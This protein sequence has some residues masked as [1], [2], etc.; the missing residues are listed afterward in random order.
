MLPCGT[1]ETISEITLNDLRDFYG[2]NYFPANISVVAVGGLSL[3]EFTKYINE[4]VF[5]EAR[6]G[7]RVKLIDG[8]TR[9]SAPKINHWTKRI[10]KEN[11]HLT[12]Q[13]LFRMEAVVARNI[14][15]SLLDL[16]LGLFYDAL[17]REFR[18]RKGWT[19]SIYLKS[20]YFPEA[21]EVSMSFTFPFNKH[22]LVRQAV[23]FCINDLIDNS[24]EIENAIKTYLLKY[25]VIDINLNH[26]L[27]KIERSIYFQEPVEGL[28][29]QINFVKGITVTQ[30]RNVLKRFKAKNRLT[31]MESP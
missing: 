4:S 7:F 10:K 26:I 22:D 11:D 23:D 24:I 14:N 16:S 17:T 20:N 6:P 31:I 2:N 29:S 5:A 30:V 28:N 21:T 27:S 9:F 1:L 15:K 25:K 13:L 8:I 18:E 19:Y 12:Q 3:E